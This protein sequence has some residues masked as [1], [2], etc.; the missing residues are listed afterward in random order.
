MLS[1]LVPI[2]LRPHYNV[3]TYVQEVTVLGSSW[4]QSNVSAG[5]QGTREEGQSCFETVQ[6]LQILCRCSTFTH[7]DL[8]QWW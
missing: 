3:M 8:K 5:Q 1:L 7:G 4:S 2:V 6:R